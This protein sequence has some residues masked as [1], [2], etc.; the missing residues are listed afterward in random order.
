MRVNSK[1]IIFIIVLQCL[2]LFIHAQVSK[3]PDGILFQAIAKDASGNPA[4]G[5]TIY[6][7]NAIIQSSI[8]GAQ[9]YVESH[10]VVASSDGVFTIVIGKGTRTSGP[11]S[12]TSID[13]SSGPYFLN[14]KAAIAPSVPLTNWNVDEHYIDMGTSQFWT[15]PFALFAAR[16]E[17]FDLKFNIADTAAML[18]P[19][20]KKSD[21][22]SL[23][24]R[25]LAKL[26]NTDTI[27]LSNRI[28][29]K[30]NGSDTLSLSDRINVKLSVAD[31]AA[32]LSAYL[33]RNEIIDTVSL[34]NRI[35]AK[36]STA[37]KST[38][39]VVDGNSDTKYPSVKAVKQYVDSVILINASSGN[40]SN[41]NIVDATLSTKGVMQLAG[42]LAGTAQSPLV[43]A[44]A[45]TTSKIAAA[46]VT[47]DKIAR[48]ISASKVGLQNV[49][50]TSDVNKPVS[51]LQ[52]AAL[53][54]KLAI[55]DTSVML[56]NYAKTIEVNS[57]I[58]T[59][60]ALTDTSA[61]LANYAKT[62]DVNTAVATK[63]AIADTAAMLDRRIARDTSYLS[64][65][66]DTK[67]NQLNQSLDINADGT[68]DIKFPSVKAVKT[69]VD[70]S[71]VANGGSSNSNNSNSTVADAD[72]STKGVIKLAGDLSGTAAIP[73][74]ANGAITTDKL[75]NNSVTDAKIASGI[76]PSKVGLGNVDNTNDADK[77]IS[78]L[79]QAALDLKFS[80]LQ[81][82][83]LTT[84]VAQKVD[85]SD[86]AAMLSARFNRDTIAL[87]N[88][89]NTKLNAVDTG[90]LSNR[91]NLKL[92]F[93]DSVYSYVTPTRLQST[94]TDTTQLSIRI[95]EKLSITDT[96]LMLRDYVLKAG[97]STL[98]TTGN[99]NDLIN[100]PTINNNSGA[101]NSVN[102]FI[103]DVVID[104]A[105]IDLG[106][107]DNTSDA[108]KPISFLTNNALIGK[109]DA[110]LI[111]APNGVAGLDANTKIPSSLL[112]PISFT[113]VSVVANATE[114]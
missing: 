79:T 36:E 77:P 48:G 24:N 108:N 94:A 5:R 113:A 111:N 41:V 74:V 25:I 10:K 84:S 13:W 26:N 107:V 60:L 71:I 50:N 59:K 14:I 89:I 6:I 4:K 7:K 20:L 33:K 51:T 29:S 73:V 102:T 21:T 28:N 82:Q 44:L 19:Y 103:G 95:D 112:P 90:F 39:L 8:T 30:L 34:S 87:S 104:K 85:I 23:S 78:T 3:V 99:Y 56:A 12:I 81:G 66:I 62:I 22:A 1:K 16:V 52:Q 106:N 37:N 98:A 46:A 45:I 65:R 97:L 38:L 61:M 86:T 27:S 109:I 11:A 72:A 32:M 75:A 40:H 64:L 91:I 70:S 96:A 18:A 114:M 17:G 100:K 15:V 35:N 43:A 68:S 76:S 110:S 88:R 80:N 67:V 105:S 92:N 31:T 49:N 9:V 47:D 54:T 2:A 63:L 93:A 69:Y 53:A 57:A 101:V 42:D 83:A 55:A 58:A